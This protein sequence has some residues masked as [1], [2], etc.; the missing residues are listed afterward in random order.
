MLGKVAV[1][2]PEPP[3]PSP[4]SSCLGLLNGAC[5]HAAC[6]FLETLGALLSSA[7][8]VRLPA[9]LLLRRTLIVTVKPRVL[10]CSS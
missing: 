5:Q 3:T 7:A 4:S 1:A 10:L 8:P 9:V 6:A 2:S